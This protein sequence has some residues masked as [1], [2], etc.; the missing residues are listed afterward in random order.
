LPIKDDGLGRFLNRKQDRMNDVASRMVVDFLI[1]QKMLYR[2]ELAQIREYEQ[3][4]IPIEPTNTI[5]HR[6]ILFPVPAEYVGALRNLDHDLMSSLTF[7][8][9]GVFGA[10]RTLHRLFQLE[11][12]RIS[13]ITESIPIKRGY[14]EL[15][16]TDVLV[17]ICLPSGTKN[18]Q[19][20]A[21]DINDIN[22]QIINVTPSIDNINAFYIDRTPDKHVMTGGIDK[23]IF[24]LYNNA[25]E[26]DVALL[27]RDKAVMLKKRDDLSRRRLEIPNTIRAD[28]LA[29]LRKQTDMTDVELNKEFLL[30]TQNGDMIAAIQWLIFGADIAAHDPKNGNT[31]LHFAAVAGNYNLYQVLT[32]EDAMGAIASGPLKTL[33]SE[34]DTTINLR[35]AYEKAIENSPVCAKNHDGRRASS[36]IKNVKLEASTS[37][38][39]RSLEFFLKALSLEAKK[40]GLSAN[41]FVDSLFESDLLAVSNV[42]SPRPT[43]QTF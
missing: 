24:D 21:F 25:I 2:D 30:A 23:Y 15:F 31:A 22:M 40:S 12:G 17:G 32:G 6:E 14:G 4:K 28:E 27:P 39:K 38:E 8:S 5:L 10:M 34:L 36:C 42:Y 19:I 13:R 37:H 41:E 20:I 3:T 26:Q 7:S 1:R 29:W 43:G 35:D 33:A 16:D 18:S 11:H 9:H